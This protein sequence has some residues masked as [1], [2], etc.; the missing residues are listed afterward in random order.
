MNAKALTEMLTGLIAAQNQNGPGATFLV[1]SVK[2]GK[3][4]GFMAGTLCRIYN[5]LDGLAAT[6]LFLINDDKNPGDTRAMIDAY[7]DWAEANPKVLEIGLSWSDTMPRGEEVANLYKRRGFIK[8][9]ETYT[10]RVDKEVR[11]AA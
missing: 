1:V 5:I 2:M 3:V 7:L 11:A 8:T 9:G 6:D 10:F 4:V